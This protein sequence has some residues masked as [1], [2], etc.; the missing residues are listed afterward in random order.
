MSLNIRLYFFADSNVLQDTMVAHTD[1][2]CGLSIHNTKTQLLSCSA[3]GTVR[4][5]SPGTKSPL[6]NTFTVDS[7]MYI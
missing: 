1:A 3:D 5:W 7:G 4:L 6:L 2:V